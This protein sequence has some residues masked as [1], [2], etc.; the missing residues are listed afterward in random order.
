MRVVH[1]ESGRH[2]YGGAQQVCYLMMG[3]ADEG[4]ENVLVCPRDSAIANRVTGM[5]NVA[6]VVEI[7]MGGD[8]DIALPGRLRTLLASRKP[9]LVHVHSRRGADKFGGWNARWAGVPAVLTRRVE[10]AEFKPL[11][12][13]KYQPYSAVIAISR[14]IE[15][16]LRDNVGLAGQRVHYVAS[17][18]DTVQYCP[19]DKRSKLQE[20]Y[21]L[22]PGTVTIGVVAQLIRRKGHAQLFRVLPELIAEFPRIHILCFG[23]GALEQ[24]LR[25]LVEDLGLKHH[26]GFTGFR[27]DLPELLPGLDLMAHPAQREGLGLAVLEA[28]SCGVPAVVSAVGGLT[29]I[30]E[31][32]VTGLLCNPSDDTSLLLALRRLCCD[33]D[34]RRRLGEAGRRR[35]VDY[36]S[37]RKMTQGNLAIYRDI[38]R[39]R[40]GCD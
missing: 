40:H 11:A 6:E 26:V 35:V 36:F 34:L 38:L 33:A 16:Q 9:N 29:D 1:L 32:N 28:L 22:A 20:I 21:S 19:S 31:D 18:V 7:P 10:S 15:A 5:N 39:R 23:Q 30:V 25:Q 3:L 2:L 12:H 8:L 13:L 37:V 24:E 27:N 14:A 4:I 17:G